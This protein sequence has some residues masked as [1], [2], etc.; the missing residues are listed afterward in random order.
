M[1]NKGDTP[2]HKLVNKLPRLITNWWKTP[3]VEHKLVKKSQDWNKRQ[4]T[5]IKT[6]LTFIFQTP[7][8]VSVRKGYYE[9]SKQ[10]FAILHTNIRKLFYYCRRISRLW[11]SLLGTTCQP[12]EY[13]PSDKLL[14][15]N[16]NQLKYID[17][18][19]K[20][21]PRINLFHLFRD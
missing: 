4:T 2:S 13:L 11:K 21:K 6:L 19:M 10:W 14:Y 1:F 17:Q 16:T 18:W 9:K 5:A 3:K 7:G 20:G 15:I 12:K 8:L